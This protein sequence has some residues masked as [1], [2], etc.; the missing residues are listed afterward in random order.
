[1]KNWVGVDSVS[2]EPLRAQV[3]VNDFVQEMIYFVSSIP[4][5]LLVTI[6]SPTNTTQ[7]L[8]P[9]HHFVLNYLG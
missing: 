5:V 9:M 3:D 1:M 4:F 2:L 6:V 7:F 8:R